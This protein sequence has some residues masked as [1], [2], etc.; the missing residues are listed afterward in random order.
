MKSIEYAIGSLFILAGVVTG[1]AILGES[2][3]YG[4][5][6]PTALLIGGVVVAWLFVSGVWHLDD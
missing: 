5:S 2:T 6:R 1:N 3:P 4:V